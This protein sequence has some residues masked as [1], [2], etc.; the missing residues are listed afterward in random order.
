MFADY[1]KE[2]GLTVYAVAKSSDI[3]YSTLNDLANGKV[4]IDN[5]KVSVLMRL[6][7]S[8]GIS[9]EEL[10]LLCQGNSFRMCVEPYDTDVNVFVKN[11]KY[12]MDFTYDGIQVEQEVCKVNEISRFYIDEIVKWRVE[13]YFHDRLM[14]EWDERIRSNEERRS[15]GIDEYK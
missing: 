9:C 1:L 2:R 7:D 13:D 6:S 14:E 15:S 4:E 5:C 11:K 10:Y 3:P 8:L 12:Y